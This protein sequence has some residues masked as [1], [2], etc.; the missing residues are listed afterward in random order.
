MSDQLGQLE[1]LVMLATMRKQPAAYGVSIQQELLDRTNR[2][3]SV[4]AIYTT[5]DRLEKKGF[6]VSRQGEATAERG[7]RRK[8]YFSLTAKG[9]SVLQLSL[10]AIE[11]LRRGIRLRGAVS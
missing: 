5:L 9:Q 3:Y 4:G 10:N 1:Q 7:G 2:E 11:S 6:V 8:M